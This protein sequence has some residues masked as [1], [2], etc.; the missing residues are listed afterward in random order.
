MYVCKLVIY[1]QDVGV[2]TYGKGCLHN[3]NYLP[4]VQSMRRQLMLCT[5]LIVPFT[6]S[7]GHASPGPSCFFLKNGWE[8]GRGALGG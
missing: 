8:E 6:S 1:T 3:I 2:A 5:E 4:Q 7:I